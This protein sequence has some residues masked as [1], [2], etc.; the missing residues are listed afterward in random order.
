MA[1]SEFV[2]FSLA[3]AAPSWVGGFYVPFFPLWLAHLGVSPSEM[4]LAFAAC[5]FTRVIVSPV[6]GIAA[7][8]LGDRRAVAMTCAAAW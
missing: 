3:Q 1:R 6:V 2:R 5:M 7:D 4:S 8:A